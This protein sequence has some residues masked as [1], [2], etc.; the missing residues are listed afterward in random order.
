MLHFFKGSLGY[1][2]SIEENLGEVWEDLDILLDFLS[3]ATGESS[4]DSSL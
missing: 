1:T 2:N 4:L 3:E